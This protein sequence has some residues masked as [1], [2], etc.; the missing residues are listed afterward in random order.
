M[1]KVLNRK[2][3]RAYKKFMSLALNVG[4]K[5]HHYTIS[6]FTGMMAIVWHHPNKEECTQFANIAEYYTDE[7]IEHQLKILE[8]FLK[9]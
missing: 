5:D 9:E 1:E 6:T 3:R 8:K 7:E 2:Y 4:L